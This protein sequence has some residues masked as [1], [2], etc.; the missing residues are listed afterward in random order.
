[1]KILRA[2]GGRL[3]FYYYKSD[4][5]QTLIRVNASHLQD[6]EDFQEAVVKLSKTLNE[7]RLPELVTFGDITNS[8][9]DDFSLKEIQNMLIEDMQI[10]E[11]YLY[12]DFTIQIHKYPSPRLKYF[13]PTF[14]EELTNYF[15]KNAVV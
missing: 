14:A 8:S 13:D 15:I 4:P 3:S 2:P 10:W 1:M 7:P 5:T 9:L 12:S 11:V 6:Y